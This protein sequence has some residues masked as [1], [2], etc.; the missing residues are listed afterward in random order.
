MKSPSKRSRVNYDAGDRDRLSALPDCLLHEIMS[1]LKARQVVQTNV[2]SKRWT[3]LWRSV[4]CLDVDHDEF[5]VADE[6][7]GRR[8]NSYNNARERWNKFE[9]FTDN[10][11][12][13]HDIGI[14]RL[15]RFGLHVTAGLARARL[16]SDRWMRHAI[17]YSPRA[18]SLSPWRV[19]KLHLSN[20][21]LDGC[22][23]DHVR[24]G[25][26]Y[27]EDLEMKRCRCQIHAIVSDSLKNLTLEGCVLN[28]LSALTAPKLK[29]L[30]VD[31]CKMYEPPLLVTAPAVAYL[32][33]ATSVN[34]RLRRVSFE[35]M[36]S[37]ATAS[38]CL[39][40]NSIQ[41]QVHKDQIKLLTSVSS[42]TTLE[43]SGFK[44]M[45]LPS[46]PLIY[47]SFP[48]F[49][50]L[51]ALTLNSCDLSDDFQMLGRFLQGSPSL[52]KLTLRR[53]KLPNH[54]ERDMRW[55]SS[56]KTSLFKRQKTSSSMCRSV[57]DLYCENLSLPEIIYEDEDLSILVK[58]LSS[59]F[60]EPTKL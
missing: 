33:L 39:R 24:S 19:K 37:L 30:V 6:D 2:L 31:G 59:I 8:N 46:V 56:R 44:K 4:P 26:P 3:H 40:H 36:P 16:A 50:N 25:C 12:I 53:C 7:V 21:R 29:S 23:A 43:L 57:I 10:L 35:A 58:D 13:R 1:Y 52:E 60:W 51:R 9:E 49:K 48:E 20:V 45:V 22:F 47:M 5:A 55:D 27:L 32:S 18:S 28:G 17:K 14:A 15:D 54:P 38:I 42:V 41:T 34:K 11:L